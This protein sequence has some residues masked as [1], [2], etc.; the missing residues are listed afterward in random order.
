[1]AAQKVLE[2]IFGDQAIRDLATH[3]RQDLLTRVDQL[4]ADEAARYL[5]RTDPASGAAEASATIASGRRAG[6]ALPGQLQRGPGTARDNL[7]RPPMASP[8]ED[9]RLAR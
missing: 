3:A 8:A 6:G 5:D 4:L 2:A 9:R 7:V 1:M